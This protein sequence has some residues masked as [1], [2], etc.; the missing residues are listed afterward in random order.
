L[1]EAQIAD[2][3]NA[4]V[5]GLDDREVDA[6]RKRYPYAAPN[7]IPPGVYR[8]QSAPVKTV[9]IWNFVVARHDVADREVKA[10]ALAAMRNSQALAALYPPASA[11]L[12][13]NADNN[14]V[15]PFHPGAVAAFRELG[16]NVK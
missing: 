15:L 11:T 16:V 2:T 6:F 10:L 5:F 9:A 14:T 1:Q 8:G 3:Q 13:S 4:V 12:A 7:A